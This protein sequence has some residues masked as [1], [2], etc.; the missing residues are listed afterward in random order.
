MYVTRMGTVALNEL[1]T[2][3]EFTKALH[4]KADLNPE[5]R[6]ICHFPEDNQIWSVGSAYG[7]NALLGK[8]CMALRIGSYLGKQQGWLAE[9]MMIIGIENPKGNALHCRRIPEPVRE[10]QS[11]HAPAA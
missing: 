6:F 4:G 10:N 3:G 8:K 9:H 5:R 7:G 11:R 1:G 2:H